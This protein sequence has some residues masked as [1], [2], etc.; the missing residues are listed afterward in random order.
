MDDKTICY[1]CGN[2][3][4]VVLVRHHIVP[5]RLKLNIDKTVTL[6]ANCH[7]KLH[8]L[9]VDMVDIIDNNI[10]K[11]ITE[12]DISDTDGS[13]ISPHDDIKN[14][15][16]TDRVDNSDRIMYI[17]YRAIKDAHLEYDKHYKTVQTDKSDNMQLRINLNRSYQPICKYLRDKDIDIRL[18]K[19]KQLK[20]IFKRRVDEDNHYICCKGQNTPPINRCIG[21]NLQKLY[22]MLGIDPS[23]FS[24][25]QSS[26]KN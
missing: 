13:N 12:E 17:I 25:T 26:V 16:I 19:R 15:I 1:F 8:N 9:I 20:A 4:D 10:E 21:I 14:D 3:D 5:R 2:P 24:Q 11:N 23:T 7:M 18:P 22:N 6:C